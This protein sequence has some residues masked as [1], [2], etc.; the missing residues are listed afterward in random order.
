MLA[1]AQ[2]TMQ[3]HMKSG[4]V[5]NDVPWISNALL[6][7]QRLKGAAIELCYFSTKVLDELKY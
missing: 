2:L 7:A 3:L 1:I 6:F 5:S 4:A